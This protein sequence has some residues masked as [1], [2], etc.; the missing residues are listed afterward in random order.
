[1]PTH[2]VRVCLAF[3]ACLA[4]HA[5]GGASLYA[6]GTGRVIGRVVEAEKGAPVA[7]AQI[8]VVE[9]PIRAVS[10][11]DGRYTLTG[12]PAGPVSLRVRMI[13]FGPKTVTGVLVP[14][15][16]TVS[17]D[18]ALAAEAVQLEEIA[19]S[20]EAERGTVNRA[21]EEQRN[22]NNIVSAVT[23]EQISKSPDSD[24]GQAVQRVSGVSVQDGKYVF[25]RGL[26]E[27]Y[28]TTSLNGS[29]IPSPEPERKIVPLDLFPAS[30]LEGIST[31]KTFTPDQPGD[32]SGASV[33]LKTR[34]FPAGRVISFSASAGFNSGGT[35]KLLQRPQT[36]G[37]EWRGLAG[38]ERAIPA[39]VADVTS[40]TGYTQPQINDMIASFRNAW[41]SLSEDGSANGGFGVTLGGEDPVFGQP[42][43]YIGSFTYSYGQEV[44]KDETRSLI[45]ATATDFQ[46]LNESH[47][48]TARNSVLYGGILNLST[49]I[50]ANSK[51]SFNN[52]YNRTADNE[53]TELAGFNEEFN[54]D[55]DVTRLTFTQ[56]TVRS[57]QLMGEHMLGQS[58]LVDWSLSGSFVNRYEPDRSDIAYITDIDPATGVSN[59]VAWLGGPRSATRTFGDLD[60]NGYEGRANYRLMLG[61]GAAPAV[62]KVGGAYRAVDRTADSRAFDI[63]NRGLG[64]ADRSRPPE[65]IFAGAAAMDSRLSLFINANGGRYDAKD[66][67]AAGYAQVELPITGRL[68]MIGGAR[69][70]QWNLD[71]NTLDPQGQVSTTTRDN[72]DILPSIALNYQL[73]ED[74]IIRLSASQTLSR[75]EYR[76]MAS[77]SSFEPI[78]GTITFGNP[79]LQRALIQN[80]DARWEWYPRAGEVLSVAVFAKHFDDPIEKVFVIQTGALA[81]SFVNADQA[82]NYGVELEVRKNLDF[83]AP[84]LYGL[85]A[86][87]NTT[88]MKSEI[89]P[90]NT[91][92][93]AL[94]STD[95]PMVGQAEYVVNGGLSYASGGGVN[96]TLLYNLVGARIVE[97][98][99]IPFPDAYEQARSLLDLSLQVP[100]FQTASLKLDAKNL[101]DDQVHVVQGGVTRLRY[102]TGRVFSVGATWQP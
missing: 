75:P 29:R 94:T 1:M 37:T 30:L 11:L 14:A 47:G 38:D 81:N 4:L 67:L 33:D 62:V 60:E 99:A 102:K 45:Q 17:Q 74:Q 36:V 96:A 51:I 24:A 9:A 70:E 84:A 20:A 57:H 42:I 21:L 22:S 66:R 63:T 56:R 43:G 76:E 39:Q 82:N 49:R 58:H 34:E 50:G 87:A 25:V 52:T 101:L 69:I 5:G 88:L 23:A 28:T 64:E 90:G 89:T 12:V 27:R 10:A 13:G 41:S 95:R 18:V 46:P 98:G 32:F 79:N 68:R 35:G 83:L 44:R 55:L 91:D 2:T 72:T 97:A 100:V 92:I 65:E 40:L 54:T 73:A 93:S 7:G 80:Y 71:L 77:V 19:V 59:P 78:G 6:Q 15:D 31:S 53:A 86:F 16:G 8:E 85:T 48:G 61:S 26:G 3:L